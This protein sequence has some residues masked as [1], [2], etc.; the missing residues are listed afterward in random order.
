MRL[1]KI[2]LAGFKSFVDPTT[3][4]LP[5]NLVGI[6]GPNGCGKS[7][8]IDAVRWVMGESSAKH[9]RGASMDDVIFNGS[10]ARKPVSKAYVE[11]VFDNTDNTLG[12]EYAKYNEISIRRQVTRDGQSQYFLNGTRCRR[13]DITDIFLGTG[14][15][16]RSYAI[17]EQGMI[18]RLIEAKPAELRVYLE[19]AAGI[20]KYKERRRETENR[21]R[22]TRDHLDRLSDLRDEIGKQ[23]SHLKRQSE[24]AEKYSS[25]RDRE[26]RL[27]AELIALRLRDLGVEL[28]QFETRLNEAATELEKRTARLREV[29]A[30]L[31]EKREQR[32]EINELFNETQG[33][34]YQLGSDISRTE[35]DIIHQQDLLKRQMKEKQEVEASLAQ[36]MEH[37]QTD[38]LRLEEIASQIAQIEPEHEL[39][40]EQLETASEQLLV[41]EQAQAEWQ[42]AWDDFNARSS[43]P[44]QQAQV[45]RARMEQL[46]RQIRQTSQRLE[47]SR[48]EVSQL[49]ADEL[50]GTIE[51][52]AAEVAEQEMQLESASEALE[53]SLAEVQTLRDSGRELRKSQDEKKHRA[54]QVR[55]RLSS[56]EALQQAAL[57]KDKRGAQRWLAKHGLENQPRLG[58]NLE[59]DA[60]WSQA[61]EVVLGDFLEAV[62]VDDI[63]PLAAQL[64]EVGEESVL[65]VDAGQGATPAAA[66][67]SLAAKVKAAAHVQAMLENVLLADDLDDALARRASLASHQSL[68]TPDGIWVGP[69]WLRVSRSAGEHAGMLARGQEIEQ[70]KQELEQLEA[71]I[72]ADEEELQA[73]RERLQ[74]LERTRHEQQEA[75][76]RLHKSQ[77]EA[78]SRLSNQQTRLE[79]LQRRKDSLQA[80]IAEMES[81]LEQEHEELQEATLKRNA[82]IAEMETLA[83]ERDAL[84][85]TRDEI[86]QRVNEA[87]QQV[88]Q[89]QGGLQ[90][91]LVRLESF[92]SSQAATQESL[93]RAEAQ[94]EHQRQRLEDLTTAMLEA[95]NPT[96]ELQT[97]LESLLAKRLEV[98]AELKSVREQLQAADN[99]LREL[100]Q[101]RQDTEREIGEQRQ[102]MESLRLASSELTVR[103]QTLMEQLD[104][105]EFFLQELLK[106]LDENITVADI[107]AELE[108][109]GSR[110]KR[111]GPI[112]LAAIEEYKEHA[113]R[114]VYLDAQNDDLVQALETLEAAIAKIDSESRA[115]FKD[116]FERVNAS[117][118]EMFPRLFGGG[119]AHLEMTENDLLTTGVTIMARPPGKRISNIHLMSG[120]EKALTAVAMVFSIFEL[121]PA[122]FCMLDEVDAPLDEAN[123]GRFCELVRSM[124][125]RV[126]FIFITHNKTT[127]ELSQQLVGVTMREPGVSRQV[128]V[129]LTE[130]AS[131]A[132]G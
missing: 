88:H 29:E 20:S 70:L 124:S 116:T 16:P 130:A 43:A 34:Y 76:N 128:D 108:K 14:L 58:E 132:T 110:I 15:G 45:E 64:G 84:A 28:E 72:A 112:N 80:E 37:I 129:D 61:V 119:Q 51:A 90:Q 92:R 31:V 6:V 39:A 105:T 123:V 47:R 50:V 26:E 55:G 30:A 17:I 69:Q 46:E 18:S 67:N 42:Q 79:Q 75:V 66:G 97:Q 95:D 81:Q 1:S 71:A 9:L 104:K 44:A 114:K 23:L 121:N 53:N 125:E 120:G 4:N 60:Q 83:E 122:P 41:A 11:L 63:T 40:S 127:M 85:A 86:A 87:R 74:A 27:Q 101:N 78:A 98:D 109:L 56:L 10:S 38:T 82:A 59:A 99:E 54:Q 25:Y 117:L 102:H 32:I 3:L 19:E 35:Q 62:T 5:S 93:L 126:Q 103:S 107:E 106:E 111:L 73:R 91:M 131:M 65:L 48:L 113:E 52:L 2:K 33:R 100:E 57:G 21:I 89:L 7:N 22:H 115:R 49:R 12:G 8:T 96:E 118:Q 77:A 36:A 13:R 24:T 68:I 94:V